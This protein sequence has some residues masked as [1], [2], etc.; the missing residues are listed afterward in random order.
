MYT[1]FLILQYIDLAWQPNVFILGLLPDLFTLDKIILELHHFNTHPPQQ[2]GMGGHVLCVIS[3]R[4][5]L[6]I[7]TFRRG[8]VH[9][10]DE[11]FGQSLLW[12]GVRGM[13]KFDI[14]KGGG[15]FIK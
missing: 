4:E 13:P 7:I 2:Q 8:E 6:A 1:Y 9:D 12:G 14:P 11:W 5:S 10:T 3:V 15:V